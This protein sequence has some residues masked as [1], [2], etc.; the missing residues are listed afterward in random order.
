L[1]C[2]PCCAPGGS[3]PAAPLSLSRT[4]FFKI[5][6]WWRRCGGG[7]TTG[8]GAARRRSCF[9]A[10][11]SG[12]SRF[13]PLLLIAPLHPLPPLS[14]LIMCLQVQKGGY[15]WQLLEQMQLPAAA[16]LLQSSRDN[17]N[18][19]KDAVSPPPAPAPAPAAHVEQPV[20]RVPPSPARSK[21]ALALQTKPLSLTRKR[22]RA[23]AAAAGGAFS[24]TGPCSTVA[25]W[26][27]FDLARACLLRHAAAAAAACR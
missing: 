21:P 3:P 12:P 4:K 19:E 24:E 17:E 18:Q 26:G 7:A 15:A 14:R 23:D 11:E 13:G 9:N 10:G 2:T 1:R 5:A 6:R 20:H 25:R 22:S 16:R 8:D 27:R